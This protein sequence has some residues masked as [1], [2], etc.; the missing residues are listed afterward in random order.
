MRCLLALA[1]NT[2]PRGEGGEA[3]TR[4]PSAG[5]Q[6]GGSPGA[7]AGAAHATPRSRS[8]PSSRDSFPGSRGEGEETG[9]GSLLPS[10]LMRPGDGSG[11]M[12]QPGWPCLLSL[13]LNRNWSKLGFVM[14]FMDLHGSDTALC[15]PSAGTTEA[16]SITRR[17]ST[18]E[19][20]Y[21]ARGGVAPFHRSSRTQVRTHA[22]T[23]GRGGG[24]GAGGPPASYRA[25]RR[26][27]CVTSVSP[28]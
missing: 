10:P 20:G 12:F 6:P 4:S 8:S 14:N 25:P 18:S 27:V 11:G 19:L 7:A 24:G 17:N 16:S 1:P 3:S 13:F 28:R 26:V 2:T 21:I 22:R 5:Q 23:R 15:P 9:S